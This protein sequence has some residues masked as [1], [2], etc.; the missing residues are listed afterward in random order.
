M[1]T[2][3]T[4]TVSVRRHTTSERI[5]TALLSRLAV[6]KL[7]LRDANG[8]V[9]VFEGRRPGPLAEVTLIDPGAARRIV[10]S[11]SI[12]LAEGYIYGEWDTP[13]LSAVL[14]LGMANIQSCA[15]DRLPTPLQ[16]VQ[17]AWHRLRA[18]TRNGARRNVAHHYDLGNDFYRL[19]LDDTMTYSSALFSKTS[20]STTEDLSEAQQRKWDRLLELLQPSTRD[21]LLEIGCGWGGFAMHVAQEAGCRVTAI[22]LSEEQRDLAARRVADAGLDGRVE[23]RLQDYRDVSE[24]YT[25][26][27]SIE[28]FEAVGEQYWPLFFRCLRDLVAAGGRIAMQTI[29][30]CEESFDAYRARPDFTQRYIFP[31]GMLPS[32]ERFRKAAEGQGLSVAEPQFFGQS[33]ACTLEKW[34]ERFDSVRDQVLAMGFDERF[35][36]MWRYY[37]AYCRTGFRS[38]NIDV[39][40]VALER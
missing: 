26:I 18:N 30:I 8:S 1:T 21:H 14:D 31:G 6:G 27:A 35:L 40:Q 3:S 10:M 12:G 4:S 38:G 32:P 22:T 2:P 15:L 24:V 17:R 23:I 28:M 19:W 37:L 25:G 9:A 5:V 39:M 16:P 29:T 36:R 20:E 7:A 33:Y 34:L 11:G 13:D